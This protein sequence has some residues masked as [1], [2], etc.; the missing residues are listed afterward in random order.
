LRL[1]DENRKC[2]VSSAWIKGAE[3]NVRERWKAVFAKDRDDVKGMLQ[4]FGLTDT[5]TL[6]EFGVHSNR[7]IGE[8]LPELRDQIVLLN[9]EHSRKGGHFRYYAG[10]RLITRPHAKVDGPMIKTDIAR[11]SLVSANDCL[12]DPIMQYSTNP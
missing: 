6:R 8:S 3:T 12:I 2:R 9:Q 5:I 4:R 11:Q 7:D 1:Y 10:A